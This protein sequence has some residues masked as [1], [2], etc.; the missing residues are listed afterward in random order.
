MPEEQNFIND[1]NIST[2]VK[3]KNSSCIQY[4]TAHAHAHAHLGILLC[5]KLSSV[6]EDAKLEIDD[7]N[8]AIL[9]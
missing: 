9:L 1:R 2:R 5:D 8:A 7:G 6:K 4:F 3:I